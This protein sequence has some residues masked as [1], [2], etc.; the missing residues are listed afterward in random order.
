IVVS[1]HQAVSVSCFSG[2]LA[3]SVDWV[4]R[5][6]TGV[7][8]VGALAIYLEIARRNRVVVAAAGAAIVADVVV[9]EEVA[10]QVVRHVTDAVKPATYHVT[11]R[12]SDRMAAVE[13]AADTV[14]DAGNGSICV[15]SLVSSVVDLDILQESV[16]PDS[17]A[18]MVLEVV[19][20]AEAVVDATL[21][22]SLVIWPVA[23]RMIEAT[24]R[25]MLCVTGVSRLA[26]SP[27]TVLEIPVPNAINAKATGTLLLDATHK[28]K[29]TTR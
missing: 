27:V 18:V 20:E 7:T 9:E 1:L 6:L 17:K 4:P 25:I 29:W 15:P 26:I 14:E 16:R 28:L 8:L 10:V 23:V 11:A 12:A 13:V 5:C 3:A 24:D 21:A 22:E 2:S 19:E